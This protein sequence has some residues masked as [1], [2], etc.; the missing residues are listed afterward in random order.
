MSRTKLGCITLGAVATLMLPGSFRA[1]DN[2]PSGVQAGA[3][4]AAA[5][6]DLF[7]TVGKSLVVESPVNIERI[8]VGDSKKAEAMAVTPRQILV[9]GKE[10]G[11]TS[12]IVWQAGGNR[13]MFD[14]RVRA[15][16][17]HLELVRQQMEKELP[18]QEVILAEEGES[19]FVRGTVNDMTSAD[20]AVAIAGALGK[21]INLLRVKLPAVQQQILLKVRFI[22]LD[23]NVTEQLGINITS[24]G[25]GR[26]IG[27]T[28][29]DQFTPPGMST[30]TQNVPFGVPVA[31]VSQNWNLS[32][33]GNIFLWRPTNNIMA[34]IQALQSRGLSQIL[35]EPNLLTMDGKPAS[36]LAGGEIPIPVVQSS[37]GGLGT[38][39]IMWKEFGVRIN[40]VPTI[41]PRKTIRL[42]VAPEV[43]SLDPA[44]GV[45]ISG[46]SVPG[47][48]VRRM[49]TE[50]ELED[51][52]SFVIGGLLDNRTT[53]TLS[54]I[55]GLGDI[56][57]LGKLFQSR[58]RNKTNTELLVLVT[59]E[60]VRPIPAG[61]PLPDIKLPQLPLKDTDKDAPR[62]PP[63]SV[64]G[65][66]A[67][68]GAGE[69]V[70]VEQLKELEK[71]GTVA[72]A[73][74]SPINLIALPN[75][76]VPQNAGTM[77][78]PIPAP[79]TPAP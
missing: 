48:S 28:S 54:K 40:F 24:L 62:T 49:Q 75:V 69:A 17:E 31:G 59:P 41:T 10:T 22:D 6:R 30:L 23:R 26:T 12:L 29:T 14:L 58:S 77:T 20:R 32:N 57:V 27:Q 5:A 38:V 74:V 13:L 15:G 71:A 51:G 7:V 33:L 16:T 63:I 3:P 67:M 37:A 2:T 64:T 70:P 36:F 45:S 18:G 47:L 79:S 55:P 56:P 61:Q 34:T 43:S 9:N 35:A 50:I 11:E 46:F 73:P 52:Q 65:G 68:P 53:E 25:L 39:T 4:P 21:P 42:R 66:S 19:V 76:A 44:S 60:L 72:T 78:S 1:A 8:S